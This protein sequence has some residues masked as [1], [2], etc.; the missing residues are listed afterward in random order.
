MQSN[1]LQQQQHDKVPQQAN[2]G[3]PSENANARTLVTSQPLPQQQ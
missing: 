3:M 2:D 1:P